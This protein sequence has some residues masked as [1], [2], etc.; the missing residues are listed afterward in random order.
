MDHPPRAIR[1]PGNRNVYYPPQ[2]AAN[3]VPQAGHLTC[4]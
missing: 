3:A 4:K 1:L 2:S